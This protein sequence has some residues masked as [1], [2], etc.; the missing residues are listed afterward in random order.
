M[1]V[2][3]PAPASPPVESM[4]DCEIVINEV[5]EEINRTKDYGI[6]IDCHSRFIQV[7]VLIKQGS[8]YL[9]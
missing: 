8:K 6:G 4:A 9:A 2:T 5:G 3:E 1:E 7:C